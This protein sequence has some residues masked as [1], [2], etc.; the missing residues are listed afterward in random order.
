MSQSNWI[1]NEDR[2]D[3][4]EHRSKQDIDDCRV[5]S[6]DVGSEANVEIVALAQ[7]DQPHHRLDYHTNAGEK[8]HDHSRSRKPSSDSAHHGRGRNHRFNRKNSGN[9]ALA[10]PANENVEFGR[11][12]DQNSKPNA[13]ELQWKL[14]E[15]LNNYTNSALAP[16]ELHWKLEEDFN[17]GSINVDPKHD[18][19]PKIDTKDCQETILEHEE[20]NTKPQ[21]YHNSRPKSSSVAHS[22]HYQTLRSDTAVQELN[23]S[24]VKS[25]ILEDSTIIHNHSR[26]PRE[27][28]DVPTDSHH[29]LAEQNAKTLRDGKLKK[30]QKILCISETHGLLSSINDLARKTGA[31]AVIHT[32]DFGFYEKES[33]ARLNDRDLRS[34]VIHNPRL[35]SG[36]RQKFLRLAPHELRKLIDR[37]MR[38]LENVYDPKL[39][40]HPLILSEWPLFA[41]AKVSFE[42]PVY[43]IPGNEED[44]CLLEKL[45][46]GLV[47]TPPNLHILHSEADLVQLEMDLGVKLTL[48]GLGGSVV[49]HRLFDAGD[50]HKHGFAGKGGHVWATAVQMGLL[51]KAAEKIVPSSNDLRVLISHVSPG[52]EPLVN[53][54]ARSLGCSLSISGGNHAHINHI[55]ADHNVHSISSFAAFMAPAIEDFESMLAGVKEVFTSEPDV[56]SIFSSDKIAAAEKC[57]EAVG[58]M[59]KLLD[60]ALLEF[61]NEG[62]RLQSK[63]LSNNNKT[64][65]GSDTPSEPELDLKL[66]LNLAI[67]SAHLGY[68]IL[69]I[70]NGKLKIDTSS[71][72]LSLPLGHLNI[73]SQHLRSKSHD[74]TKGKFEA[75]SPTFEA[76]LV[77]S[78]IAKSNDKVVTIIESSSQVFIKKEGDFLHPTDHKNKT[79][80]IDPNHRYLAKHFKVVVG[81]FPRM[82]RLSELLESAEWCSLVK[83]VPTEDLSVEL[84]NN[85]Y[86]DRIIASFAEKQHLE[87]FAANIVRCSN[88]LFPRRR[89]YIVDDEEA[90]S[91]A[92]RQHSQI[93]RNVESQP[94]G[95][96]D[97]GN[98]EWGIR[99]RLPSATRMEKEPAK[100]SNWRANAAAEPISVVEKDDFSQHWR[101][102]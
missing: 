52:T 10:E 47:P 60:N 46:S 93:R 92:S 29:Q 69:Q 39:T 76:K 22:V 17:I 37:I 85:H 43:A 65:R 58:R 34:T 16:E 32:G 100:N 23:D 6:W 82:R 90:S 99:R 77:D 81:G 74:F 7:G 67:P 66:P 11:K 4:K 63:L 3:A 61:E 102:D 42:V 84:I 95:N 96:I 18:Q 25:K 75:K 72:G 64:W 51:L 28:I 2:S 62:D 35:T 57:G 55:Y 83:G 15:V 45:A 88:S 70:V 59:K 21:D 56:S 79:T 8:G 94:D 80:D 26:I 27:D 48:F 30:S 24:G 1:L 91:Q 89:L 49:H 53:F 20:S 101:I 36:E 86:S 19:V 14:E 33:V 13:E 12:D 31:T 41:S 98:G 44:V 9:S 78:K 38:D 50:A 97:S 54:L 5:S 68:A 87:L 71:D 40:L 73:N